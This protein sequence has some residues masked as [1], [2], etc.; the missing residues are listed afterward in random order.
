MLPLED[1][2]DLGRCYPS[3]SQHG[4]I[5]RNERFVRIKPPYRDRSVF[6]IPDRTQQDQRLSRPDHRRTSK[7]AVYPD[8]VQRHT[9][10]KDT[11]A[12]SEYPHHLA[13]HSSDSVDQGRPEH[14]TTRNSPTDKKMEADTQ[15]P[16][17]AG[18]MPQPLLLGRCHDSLLSSFC[19]LSSSSC[20]PRPSNRQPDLR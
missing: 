1:P 18:P 7:T 12:P 6:R 20:R 17:Y 4:S 3:Y 8:T 9:T 15:N 19:R 13:I 5:H 2:A 16:Y 11:R 14:Q 10:R